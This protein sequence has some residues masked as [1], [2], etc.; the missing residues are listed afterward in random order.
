MRVRV[1]PSAPALAALI[2]LGCD[3]RHADTGP[4][5]VDVIGAKPVLAD[6]ARRPLD[7]GERVLA[8][9]V[10]QGLVR[11]DASG[12]VEP[13]VAERWTVINNGT[14]YIFR[15]R[16]ARWGDGRAVSSAEVAAALRHQLAR[17]TRNPLAPFLSAVAEVIEMT[18]EVLEV[19]LTR[20]R[21]DLLKL[22]AAPELAVVG[23]RRAGGTGPFRVVSTGGG[24]LLLRPAVDPAS[25][26]DDAARPAPG[27]EVRLSG[28]PAARAVAR[29]VA[30]RS[31]LVLGGNLS[32][33]PLV[34]MSGAAPGAVRVDPAAG[35]LGFA[36]VSRAGFLADAGN[37]DAL[38]SIF[39]RA[40]I[41]R[42]LGGVAEAET[43]A[44]DQLDSAAPP[45]V[46]GWTAMPLDQRRAA[47]RRL[48]AA[49][50]ATSPGPL[51]L[52]VALTAG[53]GATQLWGLVAAD[54]IE[55]GITPERVA[56]D[57]PAELRLVDEV[58]PYDSARWY[59]ATACRV[60]SPEAQA[61]LEA[62]REAPTPASRSDAL[63]TADRAVAADAPFIPLTRPL[64]WSLVSPALTGWQPN[65]RAWH[66]LNRLRGGTT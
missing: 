51:T 23:P 52:R 54:L 12:Q 57:A 32:H 58:A 16:E 3:P 62:A 5:V 11:F 9:S 53:P 35:L 45:T 21:P 18:P 29:F 30:H 50:Q 63:A 20:P 8:D 27:D 17:G 31:D 28:E 61:A 19:R 34:A 26:G 39:D 14:G 48:V 2:L 40:A 44:P 46:P 4:V 36:I 1:P 66:P 37:R 24:A 7:A 22:F 42:M 56:P 25:Q 41:A 64:R 55:V 49:W 13:G 10:A 15:L 59:L 60:C 33:W 65:A 47:M 6:A 43:L 38:A